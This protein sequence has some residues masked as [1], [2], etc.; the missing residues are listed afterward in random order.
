MF[1][2]YHRVVRIPVLPAIAATGALVIV[3]S[4]AV[5]ILAIAGAVA[6]GTSK[7]PSGRDAA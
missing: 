5:A 7:A 2:T 3:S 6:C 1:V 4:I